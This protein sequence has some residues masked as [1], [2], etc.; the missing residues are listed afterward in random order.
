MITAISKS[1]VT[2]GIQ[3]ITICILTVLLFSATNTDAQAQTNT[4]FKV[5]DVQSVSETFI[6]SNGP[7][8]TEGTNSISITLKSGKVITI[9]T[10]SLLFFTPKEVLAANGYTGT[11]LEL[12]ALKPVTKNSKVQI[13]AI[14]STLQPTVTVVGEKLVKPTIYYRSSTGLIKSDTCIVQEKNTW[15]CGEKTSYNKN[16]NLKNGVYF[17]AVLDGGELVASSSVTVSNGALTRNSQVVPVDQK[18]SGDIRFYELTKINQ[19]TGN[20]TIPQ[21]ITIISRTETLLRVALVDERNSVI[22]TDTKLVG[23]QGIF[24]FTVDAKKIASSTQNKKYKLFVRGLFDGRF[25]KLHNTYEMVSVNGK[26]TLT[27]EALSTL[28]KIVPTPR[29]VTPSRVV[30]TTTPVVPAR[31]V[32]P[33]PGF[34]PVTR[35]TTTTEV[36][37]PRPV[38]QPIFGS[39]ETGQVKNGGT[40]SSSSVGSAATIVPTLALVQGSRTLVVTA[41]YVVNVYP[42]V[43]SVTIDWGDAQVTPIRFDATKPTAASSVTHTYTKSGTYAVTLTAGSQVIKKT[44]VVNPIPT[45]GGSNL[46]AGWGV[47]GAQTDIYT[48]MSKTVSNISMLVDELYR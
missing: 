14:S 4:S 42:Q 26:L 30:A 35:P 19:I 16:F 8:F 9:K 46:P 2:R 13:A 38:T 24:K 28:E 33:S 20:D 43:A 44:V 45:S 5:A 18:L 37:V 32:P 11:V 48:E 22:M 41:T 39:Q 1:N 29:P 3:I 27:P 6:P 34:R 12:V 10:K 21:E 23:N 17:V 15:K 31:V 7:N 36:S 47:R 40:A 25:Y